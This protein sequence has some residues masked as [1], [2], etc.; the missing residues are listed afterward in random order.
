VSYKVSLQPVFHGENFLTQVAGKLLVDGWLCVL[1]H[2][3]AQVFLR[4]ENL[5]ANRTGEL[6]I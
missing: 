5:P 3:N 2:V 1:A 4:I 6:L